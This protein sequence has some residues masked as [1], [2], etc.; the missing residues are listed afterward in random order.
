MASNLNSD[1]YNH[2]LSTIFSNDSNQNPALKQIANAGNLNVPLKNGEQLISQNATGVNLVSVITD[3][4]TL[5]E[6]TKVQNYNYN[7]SQE[8]SIDNSNLPATSQESLNDRLEI[9]N[10]D[11]KFKKNAG[12]V[13]LQG[14]DNNGNQIN[15]DNINNSFEANQITPSSIKI[16]NKDGNELI[17]IDTD[18]NKDGSIEI[19]AGN[20]ELL[21]KVSKN[22]M[23]LN[24]PTNIGPNSFISSNNFKFTSSRTDKFKVANRHYVDQRH[25]IDFE[26]L[27]WKTVSTQL[28]S[29]YQNESYPAKIKEYVKSNNVP[30]RY[31]YE[32]LEDS[33]LE[34][35][36][37][38]NGNQ[39]ATTIKYE[40]PIVKKYSGSNYIIG[41]NLNWQF[42]FTRARRNT[43]RKG[44]DT[45]FVFDN[46]GNYTYQTDAQQNLVIDKICI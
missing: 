15:P 18:D 1:T 22:G 4:I 12:V 40:K 16:K 43:Q 9:T 25:R 33:K 46:D 19:R 39:I 45:E 14:N 6:R 29:L 3:D 10:R 8:P 11:I 44:I 36:K 7:S 42:E 31:E 24:I 41:T 21:F 38:D 27:Y 34:Y 17:C 23:V 37:D 35:S 32:V 2:N 30:I 20:N 28:H 13:L 26:S 5:I